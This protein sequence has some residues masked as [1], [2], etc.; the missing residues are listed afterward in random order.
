MCHTDENVANP[1]L[2]VDLGANYGVGGVTIVNR[3]DCCSDRLDAF[4]IYV[5]ALPEAFDNGHA[6]SLCVNATAPDTSGPLDFTCDV[7]ASSA[8]S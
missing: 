7:P 3:Y 8:R 1:W 2:E 5:S 6:L 4:L